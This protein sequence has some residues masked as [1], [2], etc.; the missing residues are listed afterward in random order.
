MNNTGVLEKFNQYQRVA[1]NFPCGEP[2]ESVMRRYNHEH[3]L[4]GMKV[5]CAFTVHYR[6]GRAYWICVF[7]VPRPTKLNR[8]I[9]FRQ[10]NDV[11]E[12][13]KTA[14]VNYANNT[15]LKGVGTC[16]DDTT[17]TEAR[18]MLY[19]LRPL[20]EQELRYVDPRWL[21]AME[22]RYAVKVAADSAI[23]ADSTRPVRGSPEGTEGAVGSPSGAGTNEIAAEASRVREAPKED[24]G[25]DP[26]AS[27]QRDEPD[28][29]GA[30]ADQ[31]LSGGQRT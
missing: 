29:S 22:E 30:P 20:S 31:G 16:E 4:A 3:K 19:V 25:A 26:G 5:F 8:M 24:K 21:R 6:N 23:P 10:M 9:Q 12:V 28:G 11:S 14:I 17:G 2:N 18:E 27:E 15:L 7:A 13:L 1:I